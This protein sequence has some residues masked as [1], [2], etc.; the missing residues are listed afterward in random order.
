MDVFWA[1]PWNQDTPEPA[2]D[3]SSS[4]PPEGVHGT[5]AERNL[6]TTWE[7]DEP[8]RK[9]A[10]TWDSP[11]STY[12]PEEPSEPVTE[13]EVRIPNN[14]V[15][16]PELSKKE[17]EPQSWT[18]AAESS[19][20]EFSPGLNGHN[21]P[22]S[23]SSPASSDG[24][25][26]SPQSPQSLFVG[27]QSLEH[28]G[29]SFGKTAPKTS[30]GLGLLKSIISS[31]SSQQDISSPSKVDFDPSL[32]E[33]LF[34]PAPSTDVNLATSDD[35]LDLPNAIQTWTR[36]SRQQT[37][38]DWTSSSPRDSFVRVA[39]RNSEVRKSTIKIVAKW[40][41][42]GS[43]GNSRSYSSS[44]IFGWNSIHEGHKPS[45]DGGASDPRIGGG[46]QRIRWLP[47]IT[48][49]IECYGSHQM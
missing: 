30:I 32:L 38:R 17:Q 3:P 18:E 15:L 11:W 6:W 19:G 10:S 16:A 24:G 48:S 9:D 8:V 20:K 47:Y 23:D 45:M 7:T 13:E 26:Q 5:P 25:S 1:D 12:Q 4:F 36:I 28:D 2:L 44:G 34:G 14:D 49:L 22:I 37:L 41:N 35:L 21:R 33:Q 40:R 29:D 46:S 27:H 43:K 31:N 39:W 42:D